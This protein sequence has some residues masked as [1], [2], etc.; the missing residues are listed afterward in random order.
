MVNCQTNPHQFIH[1]TEAMLSAIT[2]NTPS[3][4]MEMSKSFDYLLICS[5]FKMKRTAWICFEAFASYTLLALKESQHYILFWRFTFASDTSG[6]ISVIHLEAEKNFCTLDFFFRYACILEM[7]LPP[8]PADATVYPPGQGPTPP[9]AYARNALCSFRD[10][11]FRGPGYQYNE[12]IYQDD[13][14][15]EIKMQMKIRG[16]F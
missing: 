13:P 15:Y 7:P 5:R 16:T 3:T 8:P 2:H 14:R 1:S 10:P 4:K 11:G 9:P 12:G 6:P